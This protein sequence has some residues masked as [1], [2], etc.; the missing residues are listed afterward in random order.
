MTRPYKHENYTWF[1]KTFSNWVFDN[2]G[3]YPMKVHVPELQLFGMEPSS[4][5]NFVAEISQMLITIEYGEKLFFV[6]ANLVYPNCIRELDFMRFVPADEDV[7]RYV[8]I[9]NETNGNFYIETTH[10]ITFEDRI[11]DSFFN[12]Y[13]YD[14]QFVGD[15]IFNFDFTDKEEQYINNTAMDLSG[16]FNE[17]DP[18]ARDIARLI[19]DYHRHIIFKQGKL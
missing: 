2:V 5:A 4:D 1:I 17:V 18:K 16:F 8:A 12:L 14:S 15:M 10:T 11:R 13:V 3:L 7:S 19:V 9:H 6:P